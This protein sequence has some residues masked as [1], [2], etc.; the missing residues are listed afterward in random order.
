MLEK[1]DLTRAH[2]KLYP[3]YP[4]K[5]CTQEAYGDDGD[6]DTQH[7]TENCHK[8][9]HGN[10]ANNHRKRSSLEQPTGWLEGLGAWEE[11]RSKMPSQRQR[12]DRR[13]KVF[14]E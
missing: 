11:G 14:E 7:L 1:E 2:V 5:D 13:P 4:S 12:Y 3:W 6:G 9:V 10:L 8:G